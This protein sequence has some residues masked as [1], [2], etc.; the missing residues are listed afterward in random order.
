MI[1][2]KP[3]SNWGQNC[4]TRWPEELPF[5]SQRVSVQRRGEVLI[6]QAKVLC[7]PNINF[8]YSLNRMSS[9]YL[10]KKDAI[11]ETPQL[12]A[13]ARGS[14]TWIYFRA[15]G[16]DKA[17][18]VAP[19]WEWWSRQT[20]RVPRAQLGF[21]QLPFQSRRGS[22]GRSLES[23]PVGLGSRAANLSPGGKLVN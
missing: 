21:R 19:G 1:N 6:K 11:T 16:Q 22:R 2:Q 5:S 13:T 20:T 8:L 4:C 12:H 3:Y 14:L 7:K 9:S 23:C 17:W 10:R 18:K 15:P